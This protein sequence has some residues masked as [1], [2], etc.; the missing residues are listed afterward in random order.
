MVG[1]GWVFAALIVGGSIGFIAAALMIAGRDDHDD[2][3]D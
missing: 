3:I 2:W 1:I